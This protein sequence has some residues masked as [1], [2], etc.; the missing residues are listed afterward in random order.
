MWSDG[1]V[2]TPAGEKLTAK[3][4]ADQL[5]ISYAPT[6]LFFDESGK[7]IM[8]VES[9]VGFYRLNGVLDYVLNEAYKKFPSY[10]KWRDSQS[11]SI[12]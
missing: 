3:Q 2:L 1:G 11:K 8:R 6:L 7:E 10:L 5:G 12:R 4:W 9:V